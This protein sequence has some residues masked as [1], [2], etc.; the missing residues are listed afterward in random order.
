M[1][2]AKLHILKSPLRFSLSSNSQTVICAANMHNFCIEFSETPQEDGVSDH[3]MD[4]AVRQLKKWFLLQCQGIDEDSDMDRYVANNGTGAGLRC[5]GLRCALDRSKMRQDQ[6]RILQRLALL[7][8][9]CARPMYREIWLLC[10]R[11]HP[12]EFISTICAFMCSSFI[13]SLW[14]VK[15]AKFVVRLKE[16]SY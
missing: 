3:F 15:K 4:T 8:P 12:I 5:A 9:K 7:R 2:V 1:L 13:T 6:V 14:A 16:G 11:C 10:N